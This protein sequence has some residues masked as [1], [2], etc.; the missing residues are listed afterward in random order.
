METILSSDEKKKL[1]QIISAA[2][3]LLAAAR[4]MPLESQ[5]LEQ[6]SAS[7][8]T[9]IYFQRLLRTAVRLAPMLQLQPPFQ[10]FV[11][12]ERQFPDRRLFSEHDD[13]QAGIDRLSTHFNSLLF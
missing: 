6:F 10:T 4:E 9:H 2:E 1:A 11:D 3:K 7:H 12:N 5:P 8:L 13:A